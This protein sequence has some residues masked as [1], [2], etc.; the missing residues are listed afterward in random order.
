MF[1]IAC[2]V[3]APLAIGCMDRPTQ[4]LSGTLRGVPSMDGGPP[5]KWVLVMGEQGSG[6]AMPLD[7]SG[8]KFPLGALDGKRVTI[9]ANNK[10]GGSTQTWVVKSI[11]PAS[12]Y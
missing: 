6:Y 10:L 5:A 1:F 12:P 4:Q 7:V 3:V 9:V 8:I 11:E 2:M